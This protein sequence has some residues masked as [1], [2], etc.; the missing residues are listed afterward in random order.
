MVQNYVPKP[1]TNHNNDNYNSTIKIAQT[2]TNAFKGDNI[3]RFP[4]GIFESNSHTPVSNSNNQIGSDQ[5]TH[6]DDPSIMQKRS[7]IGH[8]DLLPKLNAIVGAITQRHGLDNVKA[9][10]WSRSPQEYY[11]ERQYW[12]MQLFCVGFWRVWGQSVGVSIG[13]W[14]G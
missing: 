4:T 11:V 1:F 7:E 3:S 8:D 5:T 12:V 13:F 6:V 14:R 2:K 9:S 10:D